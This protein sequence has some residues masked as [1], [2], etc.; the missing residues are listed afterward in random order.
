MV[1]NA[2]TQHLMHKVRGKVIIVVVHAWA[3]KIY[4]AAEESLRKEGWN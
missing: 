4:L 1:W 2:E 3:V